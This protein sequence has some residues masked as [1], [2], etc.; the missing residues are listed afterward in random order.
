MEKQNGV[1]DLKLK[2]TLYPTLLEA[3]VTVKSRYR[4]RT[5]AFFQLILFKHAE[6][7]TGYVTR[8]Y[9]MQSACTCA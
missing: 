9:M 3:F 5:L 7:V 4:I 1:L 8:S 2:L 6:R